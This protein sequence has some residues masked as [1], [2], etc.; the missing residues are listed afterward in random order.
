MG[1]EEKEK[2]QVKNGMYGVI[3]KRGSR[4]WD[5]ERKASFPLEAL[6]GSRTVV[7]ISQS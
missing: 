1:E 6:S 2:I 7:G 5:K 4:R 3:R